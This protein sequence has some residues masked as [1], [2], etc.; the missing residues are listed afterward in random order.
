MRVLI[1]FNHPYEK[2][3]CNAVLEAVQK[4]LSRAGH[5]IDLIHLDEDG[6]DPVMR[7]KDLKAF[8][9]AAKDSQA[10]YEAL[11]P[12]V[13]AYK[14]RLQAADFLIFI[15]PIWWELMP[16]LTK[17]FIDKLIFPGIAYDY[18]DKGN[19]MLGRLKQLKGVHMITTMN[20]PAWAYRALFGNAIKK[21]V[22]FGTFWK[23]GVPNRKWISLN[24]VKF[25][26]QQK[27]EKWLE[28]LTKRYANL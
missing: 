8:V 25:T 3:Y 5:S 21:A 4:G 2:S 1:V 19:R 24:Y 10:S 13:K 15:F 28:K 7:A 20:T 17:G 26:S 23:I 12:L 18:N 16:A 14:I 27:R 11:D 6:F 9:T 22:L